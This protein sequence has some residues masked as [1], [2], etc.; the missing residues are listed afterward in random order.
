[1]PRAGAHDV[2][3]VALATFCLLSASAPAVAEKPTHGS[4]L[5]DPLP[6]PLSADI[7]ISPIDPR[8][9]EFKHALLALGY[10]F[11][12][13]YTSEVLGNP[14]GGAQRSAI[15]EGLLELGIDADLDRVAGWKGAS[16]HINAFQIH[17][18][19][20][21][22]FNLYNYSTV[23]SIEAR[24]T[25][26][27]FEVWLEQELFGGLGS[28]RIGQLA[29]DS[30]FILSDFDALYWNATFGWP[31][32]TANDL[33]GTGPGYPLATPAV[34]IK[35]TPND[36]MTFLVGLF[37][38]DPSGS[39]LDSELSQVYNCCGINFRLRDPPLLIAEAQIGYTLPIGPDGL[40][41]KVRLGGWHHF[42]SFPDVYLATDGVPLANPASNSIPVAHV[43]NEA[44]YGLVD[45]MVWRHPGDDPQRGIGIFALA[46]AAPGDR[47][48]QSLEVQAGINFMGLWDERPHDA[49]GAAF[50]YNRISP[51]VS[52]SNLVAAA[53]SSSPT[54]ISSYELV[55]EA[56]YQVEIIRG[57]V[58]QPDFQ[59]V[60]RPGAGAINP[61]DPSAGLIG[62]AAVFGLRTVVKF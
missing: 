27:L 7:S 46:M 44:T 34:R 42:G 39:G 3:R 26:R 1:M 32:L 21:S 59:Y 50:S 28:I 56:T 48:L 41:G 16:F 40:E 12:V 14:T 51:L 58:V 11:Q 2:C 20:L 17:G 36:N 24:A 55:L 18:H 10:N 47:N 37:N 25:T 38:G 49:F 62:D 23:S 30:E 6:H 22:T 13:N 8:L 19:G 54:A 31:N 9:H 33:P 45:Q 4:P 43:G 52:T 15:Y 29:A 35:F 53:Y 5:Y 61:L 60:F 57:F